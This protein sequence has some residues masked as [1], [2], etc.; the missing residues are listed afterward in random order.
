MYRYTRNDFDRV[1]EFVR[2]LY[3]PRTSD[4]SGT[5]CFPHSERWSPPRSLPTHRLKL[6][7]LRTAERSA[8]IRLR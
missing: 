6:G 1:L 4:G 2:G 5:I 3:E 7:L 8:R